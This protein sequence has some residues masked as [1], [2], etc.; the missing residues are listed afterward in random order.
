MLA[1]RRRGFVWGHPPA[2]AEFAIAQ[3]AEERLQYVI[4]QPCTFGEVVVW[5]PSN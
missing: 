3:A 1:D 4:G 2:F 5:Q